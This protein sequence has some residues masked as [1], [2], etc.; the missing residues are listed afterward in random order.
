MKAPVWCDGIVAVVSAKRRDFSKAD[1][2]LFRGLA[3]LA[4]DT[5]VVW[6]K[7]DAKDLTAFVALGYTLSG[8][9][10]AW[11]GSKEDLVKVLK[12]DE[13]VAAWGKWVLATRDKIQIKAFKHRASPSPLTSVT[14]ASVTPHSFNFFYFQF[15][16]Q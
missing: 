12:E 13:G 3:M 14:T 8:I 5:V 2:R 4:E 1:L 7:N 6:E 16:Q 15:L 9:D 11:N 10:G